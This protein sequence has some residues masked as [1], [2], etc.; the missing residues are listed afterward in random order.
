MALSDSVERVANTAILAGMS[1]YLI[2]LMYG[3]KAYTKEKARRSKKRK[4]KK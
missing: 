3:D 2:K 4:K 1:L